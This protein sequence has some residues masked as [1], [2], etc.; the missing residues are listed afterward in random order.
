M[1]YTTARGPGQRGGH[2]PWFHPQSQS[3]TKPYQFC[4]LIIS[5]MSSL[6]SFS[7][8]CFETP[9]S[10]PPSPLLRTIPSH[11]A[12]RRRVP[13]FQSKTLPWSLLSVGYRTPCR[14]VRGQQ[15]WT[16][17]NQPPVPRFSLHAFQWPGP[18]ASGTLH[19]YSFLLLIPPTCLLG[20]CSMSRPW[21]SVCSLLKTS[22]VSLCLLRVA[23]ASAGLSTH[24]AT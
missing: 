21:G 2:E 6:F 15:D 10:S 5:L 14:S 8:A 4:F 23:W 19:I 3:V 17:L 7:A 20:L 12:G 13:L 16:P 18:L 11:S 22:Q 24:H 9:V 1:N